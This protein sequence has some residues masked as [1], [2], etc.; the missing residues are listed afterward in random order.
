MAALDIPAL[1]GHS[2]VVGARHWCD[3]ARLSALEPRFTRQVRGQRGAD[4][5]P[6]FEHARM[7]TG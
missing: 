7:G 4:D 6:L 2:I 3:D 5:R 1:P